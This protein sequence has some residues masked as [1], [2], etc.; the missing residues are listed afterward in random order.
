ME[1]SRSM[2]TATRSQQ[3]RCVRSHVTLSA[4]VA[5]APTADVDFYSEIVNMSGSGCLLATDRP[6][7]VGEVVFMRISLPGL[8]EV[9]AEARVARIENREDDALTGMMFNGIEEHDNDMLVQHVVREQRRRRAPAPMA[10]VPRPIFNASLGHSWAAS[11]LA[12]VG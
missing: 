3:V 1:A 5:A 8:T 2:T 9:E 10:F 6:M 12:V 7:T 11:N 4:E